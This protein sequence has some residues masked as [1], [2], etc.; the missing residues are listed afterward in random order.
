MAIQRPVHVPIAQV[1]VWVPT[2]ETMSMKSEPN[3]VY[4]NVRST[5]LSVLEIKR[6]I[7]F[8]FGNLVTK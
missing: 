6:F 5:S 3:C 1:L 8:N 4:V 2:G 7:H